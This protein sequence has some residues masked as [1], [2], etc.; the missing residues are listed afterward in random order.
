MMSTLRQI[1]EH[2]R[3]TRLFDAEKPLDSEKV[4]ECLR[5]AQLAPTS[6]NMQ[7]WECYHVVSKDTLRK[8][9]DACLGQST[10]TTAQQMVVFVTRQSWWKQ[11]SKAN[12]NFEYAN[13]R[14]NYPAEK[15]EKYTARFDAYYHKLMPILYARFFGFAGLLRKLLVQSIGLFRPIVRQVTEADL[16][17]VVHK[18]CALAVENFM[19]A[20]S[21]MGYDTCPLEGF[22]SLRVKKALG[23]PYDCEINM[24]ITCGVRLPK[25]IRGDRFRVPFDEI[26]KQ[27]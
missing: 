23:L 24:V 13:I 5:I 1:A 2:R 18:S 20:M 4:K 19:L 14:R 7:L 21:E 25:G 26:Y 3:A 8:L 9:A 27:V 15:H 10:A 11:R 6:S 22:D 17:V 16:R 12:F